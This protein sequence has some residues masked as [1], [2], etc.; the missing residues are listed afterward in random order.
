LRIFE[1]AMAKKE[2]QNLSQVVET[3]RDRLSQYSDLGAILDKSWEASDAI[4]D[5][6]SQ[7]L[8]LS[9]VYG[10]QSARSGLIWVLNTVSQNQG[11]RDSQPPPF[12]FPCYLDFSDNQLAYFKAL[13]EEKTA[14]DIFNN[15]TPAQRGELTLANAF[16]CGVANDW[17]KA[18]RLAAAAIEFG[19]T[20]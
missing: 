18:E 6:L 20:G 16:L 5:G 3:V 10:S 8:G 7:I 14:A 2:I 4:S 12:R 17:R 11:F 19:P 1:L 9:L 15:L 13:L